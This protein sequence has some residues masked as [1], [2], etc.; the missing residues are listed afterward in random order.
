MEAGSH[1]TIGREDGAGISRTL[2]LEDREIT[3]ARFA[4]R[5]VSSAGSQGES[6]AGVLLEDSIGINHE[7]LR[8]DFLIF[9][10]GAGRRSDYFLG[11][12]G[13]ARP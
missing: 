5:D 1:R 11:P 3:C 4:A 9:A 8:S 2:I 10:P 13:T 12:H 7:R 6:C